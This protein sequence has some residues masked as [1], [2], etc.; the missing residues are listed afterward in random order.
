[1]T[2][3]VYLFSEHGASA[4]GGIYFSAGSADDVFSVEKINAGAWVGGVCNTLHY[5]SMVRGF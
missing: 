1:M 4:V 3:G 2:V 5:F